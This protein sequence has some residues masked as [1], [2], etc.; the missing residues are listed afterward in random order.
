MLN[1]DC[2]LHQKALRGAARH[3][4]DRARPGAADRSNKSTRI[5]SIGIGNAMAA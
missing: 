4:R 3:D 5:Q 1:A 2:A